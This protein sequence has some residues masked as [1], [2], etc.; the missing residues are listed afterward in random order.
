MGNGFACRWL[1][2]ATTT[3]T[4]WSGML[5]V[6]AGAGVGVGAGVGAG[7]GVV[8]LSA[9]LGTGVGGG[10]AAATWVLE[11]WSYHV[12]LAAE[13]ELRSQQLDVLQCLGY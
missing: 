13:T 8:L 11:L 3:A 5:V 1:L 9:V 2:G 10:A 12:G 6:S 7:A 4:F